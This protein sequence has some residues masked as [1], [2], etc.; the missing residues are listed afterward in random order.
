ME[1]R[2]VDVAAGRSVV[3]VAVGVV[4]ST[5]PKLAGSTYTAY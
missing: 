3:G 1:G 5:S 4:A 2:E